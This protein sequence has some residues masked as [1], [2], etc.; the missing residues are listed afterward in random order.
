M[1]LL[2]CTFW[3]TLV[4]AA[5]GV[6]WAYWSQI[7]AEPASTPDEVTVVQH[8][9]SRK[10]FRSVVTALCNG[11][12][13]ASAGAA[14]HPNGTVCPRK[15]VHTSY[16]DGL[17]HFLCR[18]VAAKV[19]PILRP[20]CMP[21]GIGDG[22]IHLRDVRWGNSQQLVSIYCHELRY[23][24]NRIFHNMSDRLRNYEC[25]KVPPLD[26]WFQLGVRLSGPNRSRE[27]RKA[28]WALHDQNPEDDCAYPEEW[29]VNRVVV[30]I[31]VRMGD[32]LVESQTAKQQS[33]VPDRHDDAVHRVNLA[34]QAFRTHLQLASELPWGISAA[35]RLHV[36][37]VSD[38]SLDTLAR[39][40]RLRLAGNRTFTH[41]NVTHTIARAESGLELDFVGASNPILTLH[42]LAKSHILFIDGESF[43]GRTAAMLTRGVTFKGWKKAPSREQL[44]AQLKQ[45]VW[46]VAK[47]IP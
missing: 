22:V 16:F 12:G 11:T 10:V 29:K 14:A 17:G 36:R 37:V 6:P 2:P 31:H 19:R 18:T 5:R 32:R 45:T 1:A 46:E 26:T 43:Y 44:L 21:E 30:S 38:S 42:C 24:R 3:W 23:V 8:I 39:A 15:G 13:N 41:R 4:L 35:C 7:L 9:C 20:A 25:Y 28:Y 33:T 47:C 34:T 40:M 27:W